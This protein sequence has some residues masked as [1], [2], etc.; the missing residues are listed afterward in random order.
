MGLVSLGVGLISGLARFGFW[1]GLGWMLTSP[2]YLQFR[3]H[4]GIGGVYRG[5]GIPGWQWGWVSGRSWIDVDEFAG[6]HNHRII[7]IRG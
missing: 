3:L 2:L 4:V 6:A 7:V 5:V 1:E